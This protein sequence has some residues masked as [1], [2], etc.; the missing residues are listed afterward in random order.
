MKTKELNNIRAASKDENVR[1][2]PPRQVCTLKPTKLNSVLDIFHLL[3]SF[4][5][6]LNYLR[7]RSKKLLG[8]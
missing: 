8:M 3:K 5:I 7:F 2:S 4:N 6:T 1:L